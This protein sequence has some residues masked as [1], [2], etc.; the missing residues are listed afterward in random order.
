MALECEAKSTLVDNINP[1]SN[2][3]LLRLALSTLPRMLVDNADGFPTRDPCLSTSFID[4]NSMDPMVLEAKGLLQHYLMHRQ[5]K[6]KL[7]QRQQQ[8][9]G[10]AWSDPLGACKPPAQRQ[11]TAPA[12]RMITLGF[13]LEYQDQDTGSTSSIMEA[14]S[15]GLLKKDIKITKELTMRDIMEEDINPSSWH[16]LK[17]KRMGRHRIRIAS[18]A[19][20]HRQC[21]PRRLRTLK[22][23]RR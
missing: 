18:K 14:A 7:S 9:I 16:L 17:A 8:M 22:L 1:M 13:A 4:G 12:Q 5:R 6:V 21:H 15:T 10:A 23:P 11:R 2:P 3:A 20:A 19:K